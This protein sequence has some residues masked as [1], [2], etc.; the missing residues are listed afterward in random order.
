MGWRFWV[1]IIAP[2]GGLAARG[3]AHVCQCGRGPWG[4]CGGAAGAIGWRRIKRQGGGGQAFSCLH[5]GSPAGSAG[6]PSLQEYGASV[7]LECHPPDKVVDE[8]RCHSQLDESE[9]KIQAQTPLLFVR[10][11]GVLSFCC[12]LQ[13]QR[14]GSVLP[15]FDKKLI[16]DCF[17]I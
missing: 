7:S 9:E 10:F 12:S 11:H 15:A 3:P 8:I 1:S 4:G 14:Y 6:S 16:T 17:F 5:D 13:G 2:A